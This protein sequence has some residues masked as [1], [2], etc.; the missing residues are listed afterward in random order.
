MAKAAYDTWA[1]TAGTIED[2]LIPGA[3]EASRCQKHT[4]GL[5]SPGSGCEF[6]PLH[7]PWMDSV[8]D[9]SQLLPL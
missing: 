8:T 1:S 6:Y 7:S 2:S 5:E 9:K 4:L 3:D